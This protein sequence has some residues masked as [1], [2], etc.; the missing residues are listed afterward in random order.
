VIDRTDLECS[1]LINEIRPVVQRLALVSH[2]P[3]QG[4]NFAPPEFKAGERWRTRSTAAPNPHLSAHHAKGGDTTIPRGN[5]DYRGDKTPEY[6]QKSADHF[7]RQLRRLERETRLC[8]A[9]DLRDLLKDAEDALEAWHKTPL[10]AGERPALHD[11]RWKYWA[12]NC[13]HTT[14]D[15]VRWYSISRQYLHQIRQQYREGDAA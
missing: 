10:I 6:R 4:Y 15:L 5:V 12:A 9:S 11:P 2:A 14:A 8:T 7:A 13:D 3:I 1:R